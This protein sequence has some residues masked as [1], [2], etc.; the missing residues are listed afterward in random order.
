[1]IRVFE[2]IM[3]HNGSP[4]A[5]ASTLLILGLSLFVVRT[6][7]AWNR[8]RHVKGPRLAGFSKLWL[9]RAVSGGN[10]HMEFANANQRYGSLARIGP[11][12]LVTSDPNQMRRML[13]VRSTYTR[14]EWYIGMK[15][16]PSRENIE[17]ER[18]E[19][20]HNALRA[21]MAAGYSGKELENMEQKIDENVANLVSLVEKYLTTGS[22]FK[23]FD[24]GRK[25]QYFTLDVITHLAYGR[26][27]G[28]LETDSDVYEYIKTVE[29]TLP[30]AMLVT[31]LPWMN[32]LLQTKLVK[33]ILPSEK[34][35]IGFGKLL[36]IAKETVGKRFGPNAEEAGN[37]MLGSFIRHGLTKDEAESETILQII[38]G[39]DTTAV[40]VRIIFLHLMSNPRI[41]ARF[42]AEI[43]QSSVSSPIRDAEARRLPYLQAII[44][45]GLRYWP[46]VVGLMAKEVPPGGD[47]VNGMFI[48]GG[49]SI[50][51]DAFGIFRSKDIFGQDANTF[52]PERWLEGPPEKTKDLE[53]TLDLVFSFGKYQ[54]LGRNVALMELNKVFVELFRRFDF[55]AVDAQKPVGTNV[56]RGIFLIHN[57]WLTV[58]RLH[59]EI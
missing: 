13:G 12:H 20:K 21:K 58:T 4:A 48:P 51:Y 6:L 59:E 3:L 24:F 38:A 22:E 33:L 55:A 46:P 35:P 15:F 53:Q 54:C 2:S 49:T 25:A 47:V 10:M 41:L 11:N 8:L 28:F 18:N 34:D 16:D 29:E 45:E 50:G 43:S 19:D 26:A 39:S 9:I 17:S 52:R 57:F 7:L 56:A 40:A 27:F 31:V 42:R 37:D 23:P 5:I 1:M 14:S 44:K 30:A 32:W 36:G